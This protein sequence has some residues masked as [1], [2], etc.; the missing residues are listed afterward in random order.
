MSKT[1]QFAL[2]ITVVALFVGCSAGPSAPVSDD[3]P[4]TVVATTG[5]IGDAAGI[6]GGELVVVKTLMGPGVDPH[7][8]K[9]SEGDVKRL[10]DAD[11]ILYNGLHLEGKMTDILVKLASRRPIVA[12]GGSSLWFAASHFQPL[13]FVGLL[14][15]GLVL[16]GIG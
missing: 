15:F 4:V 9:A 16:L 13:Q 7:L 10:G 1:I 6:V 8:Y 11:L 14:A 12:V 3:D 2:T 5:M